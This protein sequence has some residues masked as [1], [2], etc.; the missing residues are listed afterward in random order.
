MA[1]TAVLEG[2][3]LADIAQYHNDMIDAVGFF[4]QPAFQRSN[5]RFAGCTPGEFGERLAALRSDRVEETEIRSTFALL[6]AVEAA[7]RLSR[8]FERCIRGNR[9]GH[10]SMRIS[11]V[12]GQSIILN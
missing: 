1:N 3:S 7:L 10:F 8:A 12:F 6:A 9:S 5:P 2:Q 4:W 11:W